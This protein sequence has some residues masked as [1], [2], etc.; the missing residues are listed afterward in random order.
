MISPAVA[1]AREQQRPRQKWWPSIRSAGNQR[2]PGHGRRQ[3]A[4]GRRPSKSLH[5]VQHG[6]LGLGAAVGKLPCLL[7]IRWG[8]AKRG[9]VVAAVAA[10]KGSWQ[11]FPHQEKFRL[12]HRLAYRSSLQ[13]RC[14][15]LLAQ[16]PSVQ[17][18]GGAGGA[19]ALHACDR[20]PEQPKLKSCASEA[21]ILVSPKRQLCSCG[22][23][24]C[25][26]LPSPPGLLFYRRG[27]CT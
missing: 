12:F 25:S 10:G 3:P 4:L 23:Q 27:V 5:Q 13:S 20:D 16:A 24:R 14:P 1:A 11:Q 8:R 15:N 18:D 9:W 2:L 6:V 17:V 21:Q 7:L 19:L 22:R 26:C